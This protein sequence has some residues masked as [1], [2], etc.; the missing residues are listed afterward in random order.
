MGWGDC[1]LDTAGRPVGYNISSSCD[2]PVCDEWIDRGLG[3][4]CGGMH[5]ESEYSC[6]KYFCEDHM[7]FISIDCISG[8]TGESV[9]VACQTLW[10]EAHV[11]DC[12]RCANALES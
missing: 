1:G 5:G 10:E 11:K 8:T 2:D 7:G 4:A 3:Y 6:E 9:C 12:K